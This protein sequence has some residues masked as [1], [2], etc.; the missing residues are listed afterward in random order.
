[1]CG[2]Y[3][4]TAKKEKIASRFNI[5]LT[6]DLKPRYNVAPSQTMPVITNTNP[7]ELSF[8]RWGLIPNWALDESSSMNMINARGETVL[9]RAPF[10]Q[11]IRKQRCLILADG[12]Y[13]WK[14]VGKNKEPYRITLASDEPFA[15]AGLWDSWDNGDDVIN[16]YTIITTTANDLVR[17]IHERMP[18]ILPPALEREWLKEDIKDKEIQDLLVPYDS[19][20]MS[21]YKS[22]KI[23]N[24]VNCDTPECIQVAPKIY[25]GE[26][27]FLFE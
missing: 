25:P 13:E 23:V 20:K 9:T 12:F 8:F 14:K 17:D 4:L 6:A 18:V 3:S 5:K 27:Y 15:F 19:S 21:Y 22:H 11:I 10:K 7:G 16:T 26:T 24:S 2:R 1:M